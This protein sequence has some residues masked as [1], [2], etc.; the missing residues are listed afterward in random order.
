MGPGELLPWET[1]VNDLSSPP[2]VVIVEAI[3]YV[4]QEVPTELSPFC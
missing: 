2:E 1:E 4:S 3:L